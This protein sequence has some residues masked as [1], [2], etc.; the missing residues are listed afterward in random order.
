MCGFLIVEDEKIKKEAFI[1]ASERL[2]HRGPDDHEYL[3][4]CEVQIG[5]HRLA[6]MDLSSKG[7]QPFVTDDEEYYLVCNGEIYNHIELRSGPLD[8]YRYKSHSDCEVIIPLFFKFGIE[9]MCQHLDGEYA[10]VLY[11]HESRKLLAA[12][13]EMGIRPMFYGKTLQGKMCFASEAK[14]LTDFCQDIYPFP[15]GHYF[16]G[17]KIV[18]FHSFDVCGSY[19]VNNKEE[20]LRGIKDLLIK[21]VEKRLVSD[22]P[23]GFLLSGG[24]DS[25][26]VCSIAAKVT[27][28]KIT[29]FSVG[30]QDDPIDTKYAKI[31]ADYLGTD[32][33]EI[34]FT[35][36]EAFLHLRDLIYKLETYDITTIRAAMGMYLVCKYVKEN[37]DIKVILTGEVSDEIFGYKYTDFAPGPEEFQKE[38]CKRVRELFQYDVLR[39]DRCMAANS[40]EARVPF[41]DRQF[42]EFVM[43][44]DPRLKMNT[45]GIGKHILRMAFEEGDYLPHD[46]LY[47]EKAAFSD[48]VGHSHVDNY[49]KMAEEMY[50]DEVFQKRRTTFK[51]APPIT[52][53][54]LM[55][56][57]LFEEVLPGRSEL[58]KDFWMPNREWNNCDVLDP[59]AR[60]LPNYGSSGT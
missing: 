41:S 58:V 8:S 23:I 22:A 6:I 14:A 5:F 18:K 9:K 1:Q 11:D 44:I 55:Y 27:A 38:A 17:E 4:A 25:S 36:E 39:A 43:N 7:N 49:K 24:L 40:L 57:D 16:D 21:G 15:P 12:R 56:R 52:K 32:H 26:L 46:I 53:E 34:L 45:T 3:Q 42:V 50:S 51:H 30:I 54:A 10:F 13:D 19:K 47:R 37:T 60:A 31:V 28:K 48:A 20:A 59:S 35:K 33:H 29:T 2:S